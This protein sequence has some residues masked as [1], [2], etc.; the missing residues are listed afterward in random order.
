MNHNDGQQVARI[1]VQAGS[2]ARRPSAFQKAQT[3]RERKNPTT[4]EKGTLFLVPSPYLSH[5]RHTKLSAIHQPPPRVLPSQLPSAT[6]GHL[7]PSP[8][9]PRP[10]V[11]SLPS[12]QTR[13]GS[14]AR[15]GC[16]PTAARSRSRGADT[17]GRGSV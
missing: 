17:Q 8:Q 7:T 6:A 15:S 11:R 9:N 16:G 1:T 14:T 12:D 2:D 3:R 4:K 5:H 13:L 10:H